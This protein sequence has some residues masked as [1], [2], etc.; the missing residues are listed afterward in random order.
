MRRFNPSS[1]KLMNN[2]PETVASRVCQ[3]DLTVGSTPVYNGV[4]IFD[5]RIVDPPAALPIITT[6][7]VN[8]LARLS[9][10]GYSILEVQNGGVGPD[11]VLAQVMRIIGKVWDE[12]RDVFYKLPNI[13]VALPN[14]CPA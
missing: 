8:E 5:G 13:T 4:A 14:I 1:T 11:Q 3:L 7:V 9:E 2:E 10:V 6:N 12:G